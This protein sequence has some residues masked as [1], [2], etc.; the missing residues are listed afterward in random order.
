MPWAT[1]AK[2]SNIDK[3][4]MREMFLAYEMFHLEGWDVFAEDPVN[5]LIAEEQWRILGTQLRGGEIDE[6]N[7]QAKLDEGFGE[8][9]AW[10]GTLLRGRQ[11]AFDAFIL[12]EKAQK[13]NVWYG[14]LGEWD[15][16]GDQTIFLQLQA[17]HTVDQVKKWGMTQQ[18]IDIYTLI[19]EA[20]EW[21]KKHGRIKNSRFIENMIAG[22][23]DK[24]MEKGVKGE[25][26]TK[27]E[28]F[29]A[30]IKAGGISN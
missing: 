15:V 26:L 7:L 9:R 21:E 16:W 24:V 19:Y 5:D 23:F 4:T 27:R 22:D 30:Y 3:T 11:T 12:A 14:Q 6:Q 8:S 2:N 28:M 25:Q 20:G 10:V 29:D 13:A 18:I 17:G 1:G